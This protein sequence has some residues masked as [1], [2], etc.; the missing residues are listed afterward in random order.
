M[1]NNISFFVFS[2]L[3]ADN[4]DGKTVTDMNRIFI[5]NLEKCKKAEKKPAIEFSK[6][7]KS[8][9]FASSRETM[10]VTLQSHLIE[11]PQ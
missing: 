8:K 10:G 9:H 1:L 7:I 4:L 6:D 5:Q 2:F 3:C 11:Y